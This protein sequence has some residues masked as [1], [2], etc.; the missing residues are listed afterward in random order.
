MAI[1]VVCHQPK[2]DL[3]KLAPLFTTSYSVKIKSQATNFKTQIHSEKLFVSL[4]FL[5]EKRWLPIICC[6]CHC[7]WCWKSCLVSQITVWQLFWTTKKSKYC[8]LKLWIVSVFGIIETNWT[9]FRSSTVHTVVTLRTIENVASLMCA[10]LLFITVKKRC[11]WVCCMPEFQLTCSNLLCTNS[12]FRMLC[13][14]LGNIFL[15]IPWF[16]VFFHVCHFL[17]FFLASVLLSETARIW[18]SARTA[19][20]RNFSNCRRWDCLVDKAEGCT[21]EELNFYPTQQYASLTFTDF[22]VETPRRGI[23][24]K[25]TGPMF[26]FP[27][28]SFIV[29]YFLNLVESIVVLVCWLHLS[30]LFL[31]VCEF[32]GIIVLDFTCS[33][34]A[35]W[36]LQLLR[37]ALCG[38]MPGCEV[39]QA[40]TCE[41]VLAETL[42]EYCRSV[43]L[44]HWD[45][46]ELISPVKICWRWNTLAHTLT[47]L[48]ATHHPSTHTHT[49]THTAVM[50]PWYC[51]DCGGTH[52]DR[53][54][55]GRFLPRTH[56]ISG[57]ALWDQLVLGS[58]I[59]NLYCWQNKT[60]KASE[61]YACIYVLAALNE[62]LIAESKRAWM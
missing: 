2:S 9:F 4:L 40:S 22:Q 25:N 36:T 43:Y 32:L 27:L 18:N 28:N 8:R 34:L 52:C 59:I 60:V 58:C 61:V 39:I 7:S 6:C 54:M 41:E 38:R 23:I 56:S 3:L 1:D 53:R 17:L 21:Q 13:S 47:H 5:C 55:H 57:I 62:K 42:E 26:W 48:S 24:Q 51:K 29:R 12:L 16:P 31:W 35:L 15:W 14:W 44:S 30:A 45:L 33:Q 10:G 37:E 20:W 49:H 50:T 46:W 19:L 11:M